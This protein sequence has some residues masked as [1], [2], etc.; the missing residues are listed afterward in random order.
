MR[1]AIAAAW[2]TTIP[3]LNV[4]ASSNSGAEGTTLHQQEVLHEEMR[5]QF[6]VAE[7]KMRRQEEE[8]VRLK[9]KFEDWMREQ[10]E[11]KRQREATKRQQEA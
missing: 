10:E 2:T 7:D 9:K 8:R 5:G 4:P 11:E 6:E 1:E 3:T